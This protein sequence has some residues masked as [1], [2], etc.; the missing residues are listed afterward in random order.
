MKIIYQILFMF[1]V[2]LFVACEKAEN[3]VMFEGGT[4]PDLTASTNTV[5]L[6]PGEES[7][8][9]IKFTWTNPDYKF[10]TGISSHDV[11][12]RLEIDTLG[13]AFKSSIKFSEVLLKELSK[14]YTVAE[15]NGI[16][17]NT[18]LLQLNPRRM[19]TFQARIIASLGTN[20]D[21]QPII[22]DTVSFTARP[23]APPPKVALPSSG[24]LYITGGATPGDWMAGGAS[25]LL[26]QK[27]TKIS[28]TE[29]EIIVRLNAG[30]SYL[31]VPV[32]GDWGDKY[33][34]AVKNDP[35]LVNGGD[36]SRGS[37]D[38]M[39]PAKT[40]NYK[41]KVNFQVGKF[42]VVEQP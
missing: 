35:A 23:F 13:G 12:Y 21:I 28:N 6:E 37:N 33:G 15:L 30:G 26:S 41:I 3:K 16:F 31:F 32:Y 40:A 39:A 2:T 24:N 19:Y 18:M 10:N 7:N 38:I 17:G 27:F 4:K 5:R 25:E 8:I 1:A 14:T 11:K 36:F 22:S 29:Y 34:I 20:S 9:A 42:T